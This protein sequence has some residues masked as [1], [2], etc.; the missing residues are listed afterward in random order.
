MSY[1]YKWANFRVKNLK[2]TNL[3]I[4][5]LTA[6]RVVFV[7]TG[8]LLTDDSGFTFNTTGDILTVGAINVAGST[9]PTSGW[10]LPSADLIRTPNS[11]TIDDDLV[12]SG[13]DLTFGSAQNALI[14]INTTDATD[15]RAIFMVA[16]GAA[17]ASRGAIIQLYGNEHATQA[18]DVFIDGGTVAGGGVLIRTSGDVTN[19]VSISA[20]NATLAATFTGANTTLAGDLAVNGGDLTSSATTFNLLNAT[21]TTLNVGQAATTLRIGATGGA[22]A[23]GAATLNF[24]RNYFSGAFTSG[25]G[26]TV[27]S[28]LRVDSAL[29]GAAGDTGFLAGLS[30]QQTI[31]TQGNTDTIGVVASA[32]IQEPSITVGTGDTITIAASIYIPSA[33]TEGATNDAIHVASGTSRFLGNVITNTILSVSTTATVFNTVATTVNAF[34]AASSGVNIGNAS[35]TLTVAGPLTV[36]TAGGNVTWGVYTP[37]R[38]AEANLDANVTPSE[39]QYTRVGNTVTVS[40]RFTA[41][42]TLTATATSFELTL[43]VSSNIGAVEDAAGV[44]FCG[45][46][47]GMGAAITGSVANNTAVFSWVSSD[48]TSQSWSYTYSYQVI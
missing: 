48:V 38:S 15:N 34:G 16:G 2:A 43:P 13:G 32:Y 26:S 21:V 44:A 14:S 23:F 9:A 37:T 6:T 47:A 10:Y 12:I 42:P 5:G 45:A 4:S 29:T 31:T 30:V 22:V 33:P 8:G 19:T 25:G 39:A 28:L 7:G 36:N 41:D 20:G 40:G 1:F 11:V 17:A 27:A 24:V 18:G 35:G 3:T 46:I